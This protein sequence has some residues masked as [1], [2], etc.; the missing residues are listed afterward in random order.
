[1]KGRERTQSRWEAAAT[2]R[3]TVFHRR[4]RQRR[5]DGGNNRFSEEPIMLCS[6]S[7]YYG[8]VQNCGVSLQHTFK[9]HILACLHTTPQ[10]FV[11][12]GQEQKNGLYLSSLWLLIRII[13]PS[14]KPFHS[15]LLPTYRKWKHS[16]ACILCSV[17][18]FAANTGSEIRH[19]RLWAF[20]SHFQCL[21][22]RLYVFIVMFDSPGE[23][24]NDLNVER[25][26]F[27]TD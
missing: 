11:L 4:V 14:P 26:Y 18:P 23:G 1:M 12:K 27:T 22:K 6:W 17:I 2:F 25:K 8:L 24:K 5:Y 9:H 7:Y 13:N 21:T 3:A 16:T 20:K 10:G 15:S 19:V